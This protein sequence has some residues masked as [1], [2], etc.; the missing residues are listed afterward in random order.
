MGTY[1]LT[2][3][4]AKAFDEELFAN[5]KVITIK[6]DPSTPEQKARIEAMVAR[7]ELRQKLSKLSKKI[8]SFG[9]IQEDPH[10]T[11]FMRNIKN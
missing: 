8:P 6:C 5:K 10:R 1:R 2:D 11:R 9:L 4:E 7:R 3:A